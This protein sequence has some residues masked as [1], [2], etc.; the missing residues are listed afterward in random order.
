MTFDYGSEIPPR[1]FVSPPSLLSC[2][3]LRSG[4]VK[5]LNFRGRLFSLRQCM[6]A[7]PLHSPKQHMICLHYFEQPMKFERYLD[8]R[9]R[10][11]TTQKGDVAFLPAGAPTMLHFAADEPD[12]SLSY[13]YLVIEHRISDRSRIIEWDRSSARLYPNLRKT[14]P[15]SARNRCCANVCAANQRPGG[16]S[17]Y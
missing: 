10:R 11:E 9:K 14:R 3:R 7:I 1:E 15:F 17:L 6:E 16:K 2:I 13:S 5:L 4:H 12:R 8:G